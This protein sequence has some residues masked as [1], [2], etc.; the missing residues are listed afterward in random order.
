MSRDLKEVIARLDKIQIGVRE[1][2]KFER[3]FKN[4]AFE[5][6]KQKQQF[7]F[8]NQIMFIEK[9]QALLHLDKKDRS[10]ITKLDQIDTVRSKIVHFQ[11]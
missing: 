10:I 1:T 2:G 11:T 7:K 8:N 6:E 5:I 3:R 4:S 9:F